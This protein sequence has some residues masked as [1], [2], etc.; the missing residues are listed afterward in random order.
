MY[1][2]VGYAIVND[3]LEPP[4]SGRKYRPPIRSGYTT[5][6]RSTASPLSSSVPRRKRREEEWRMG[7][8]KWAIQDQGRLRGSPKNDKKPAKASRDGVQYF[9]HQRNSP[10]EF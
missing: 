8:E 3:E 4:D 2:L 7:R 9:L 6:P 10:L 1:A 5:P